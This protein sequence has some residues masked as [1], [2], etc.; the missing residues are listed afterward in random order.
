MVLRELKNARESVSLENP[1]K[2]GKPDRR[3]R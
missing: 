2:L 3:L 1:H